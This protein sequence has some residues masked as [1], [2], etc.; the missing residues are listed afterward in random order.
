VL[1]FRYS[2]MQTSVYEAR[3]QIIVDPSI[4]AS[5]T[6]TNTNTL[7]KSERVRESIAE[8]LNLDVDQVPETNA[9]RI[10]EEKA[11]GEESIR[12]VRIE[13]DK[14]DQTLYTI[15]IQSPDAKEAMEVANAWAEVGVAFVEE[16][17]L[18]SLNTEEDAKKERDEANR[19]LM[20]YLQKKNLGNLTWADLE[21]LTGVA[22]GGNVL[23]PST[24]DWQAKDISTEE[25][26]QIIAL[27]EAKLDADAVYYPAHNQ[28]IQ[29]RA[30]LETKAP[31]VFAYAVLP[32]NDIEPE[33][34]LNTALGLVAGGMLGVFWVFAAA[35]WQNSADEADK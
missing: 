15:T 12:S 34:M 17:A 7:L 14:D 21:I 4:Y 25:R 28:A 32:A 30:A 18:L 16:K 3:A 26:L 5:N 27:M 2:K 8:N 11:S 13:A 6:N 1:A 10:E 29:V 33:T 19:A 9:M 23:T 22:L 35:W 31:E 24:A 20:D